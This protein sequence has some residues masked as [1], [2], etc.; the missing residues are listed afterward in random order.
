ML[1]SASD[2]ASRRRVFV[3]S[4][5]RG[6]EEYREAARR[7]IEAAGGHPILVNEDFPSLAASSRN[8]CLD[9]VDSCDYLISVVGARGGWTTPS[10]LLV[11][12]EEFEHARRR[13]LPV[14]VFVQET[15]RDADSDRFVRRLTDYVDGAFRTVFTTPLELQHEVRRA[16][17]KRLGHVT[18]G[19]IMERDLSSY[20]VASQRESSGMTILRLVLAPERD[21]EVIDPVRMGSK[22]LEEQLYQIGHSSHVR[23]MSYSRPK[24]AQ[25]NGS[26]LVIEQTETAGRHS[27]G[28]HVRLE[29]HESGVLSIDANVT[30]RVRRKGNLSMLDSMIAVEDMEAVL[31]ADFRF[32]EALFN[33]LDPYKRHERFFFNAGLRGL[34]YRTFER[35]PQPR[36]SITMSTRSTDGVIAYDRS[37]VIARAT[38]NDPRS[39]IERAVVLLE[40]NAGK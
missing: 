11:V 19:S 36:S 3:S 37:R 21:E 13:S 12:E 27:E 2:G 6:F 22:E 31:S 25:L 7:G 34:G 14:F 32:A 38:L 23:L 40:R 9:A 16:L 18:S 4:V 30:G 10:G 15:A 8:A 29:L 26:A 24:S 17:D 35:N 28:E 5:V 1:T 33:T 20:F 39:E